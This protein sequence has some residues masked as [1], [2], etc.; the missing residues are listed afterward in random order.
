MSRMFR[1][2]ISDGN[3]TLVVILSSTLRNYV[4]ENGHRK[5]IEETLKKIYYSLSN[6][7]HPQTAVK[8]KALSKDEAVSDRWPNC[9][10]HRYISYQ[11]MY[12]YCGSD[13]TRSQTNGFLLPMKLWM[14]TDYIIRR[15]YGFIRMA[16]E[17]VGS[18]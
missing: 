17:Q 10:A 7:L 18:C 9:G 11:Q 2:K 4:I 13:I 5:V 6:E 12:D 15:N 16:K 3:N 14:K 1:V 8:P